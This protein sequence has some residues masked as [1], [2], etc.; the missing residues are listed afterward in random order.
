[1]RE[2]MLKQH[3]LK[4]L[5]ESCGRTEILN[6]IGRAAVAFMFH[7]TEKLFHLFLLDADTSLSFPG[8]EEK[9]GA[10]AVL[11]GIETLIGAPL[12]PGEMVDAHLCS[13]KIDFGLDALSAHG[14]WMVIAAIGTPTLE[15]PEQAKAEWAFGVLEA[16]LVSCDD[17]WKIHK[18]CYRRHVRCD[19]DLGWEKEA[20]K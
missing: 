14:S 5:S 18:L 1:M 12:Q 4:M 13:P 19:Y 8:M 20:K 16:D 6:T 2:K 7:Q 11:E 17:S 10:D 3:L 15:G 9:H